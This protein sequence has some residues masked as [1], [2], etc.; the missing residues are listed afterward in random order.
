MI[1]ICRYLQGPRQVSTKT[2]P[3]DLWFSSRPIKHYYIKLMRIT[4]WMP[5]LFTVATKLEP[6]KMLPGPAKM[7][8]W[9]VFSARASRYAKAAFFGIDLYWIFGSSSIIPTVTLCSEPSVGIVVG[10]AISNV[11]LIPES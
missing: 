11:V 6:K 10:F 8:Y 5:L 1:I 4:H 3:V 7:G 2:L 9:L